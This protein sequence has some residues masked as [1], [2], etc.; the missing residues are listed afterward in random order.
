[1]SNHTE[2]G[3]VPPFI[4]EPPHTTTLQSKTTQVMRMVLMMVGSITL[5]T[6]MAGIAKLLWDI[7]SDGLPKE[8]DMLAAKLL[9]LVIPFLVGWIVSLIDIRVMN[10][11]V[12]P[13]IIRGF[14]WLTLIGILFVYLRVIFK[15]YNESFAQ[16]HYIH[17]W[18]VF[19]TGFVGMVGLHL[20]IE[21]HDLR[22]YAMPILVVALFHL[23]L[24]VFHYA[25]QDGKPA[26]AMGDMLFFVF[27][28]GMCMLMAMHIG[29]LNPLRHTLDKMFRQN[30]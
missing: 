27:M 3:S 22:P 5:L 2:H 6:S 30:K 29:L 24:A 18:L 15:F 17:Y 21:D 16:D 20:L 26:Y 23:F 11:L 25:F 12:Q 4:E 14:L 13:L 9:W 7:L 10:S 19:L 28:L 1:M 8:N